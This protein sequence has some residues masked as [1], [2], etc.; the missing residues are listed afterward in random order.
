MQMPTASPSSIET[1]PVVGWTLEGPY[2]GN[3]Q[4]REWPIGTFPFRVGRKGNLGM[5]ISRPNVSSLH[6]ELAVVDNELILRDLGSTNGTFVNGK[7]ITGTTSV[8]DNDLVQFGSSPFRVRHRVANAACRTIHEDGLLNAQSLMQFDLLMNQRAVTPYFQPIVDIRYGDIIGYEILG[9][10]TLSL[11]A[12]PADMFRVASQLNMEVELSVL[13]R[14]EGMRASLKLKGT[15]HLFL[16]THPR[17]LQESGLIR[18]LH[19]LRDAWP[20]QRITL[21][22]HESAVTDCGQMTELRRVLSDLKMGLAYD[23]FG[24][25]QSRLRELAE[26][27]PDYLKFDMSL[28]RGIHK[29]SSTRIQMLELLVRMALSLGVKPLAEGVECQGENETCIDVGFEVGQGFLYGRPVPPGS[30]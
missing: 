28:I 21:E 30:L 16:N 10:S 18:S 8:C 25:G 26:F 4:I 24:A 13:L 12:N 1:T 9:R 6:A 7:Q 15:P 23:D 27:P 14:D 20:T 22:I 29:A 5:T 3:E 17:E 11:L 2:D 19:T